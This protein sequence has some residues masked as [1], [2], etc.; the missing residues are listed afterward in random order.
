VIVHQGHRIQRVYPKHKTRIEVVW[1]GLALAW[2]AGFVDAIGYLTLREIYVANMSGN[3]VSV[4]IHLSKRDWSA[5]WAHACPLLAFVPGLVAGGVIVELCKRSKLRAP[6]VLALLLE[7]MAL[8]LFI[9]I[10]RQLISSH[11][12]I[13]ET[14]T[15]A[16]ALLVG[17][18]A[19]SMGLQNGALQ[20]IGALKDVH[21]YVT[22][23][24]LAMAD[25]FTQYLFWIGRR[26]RQMSGTR[27]CRIL[28]YSTRQHS[29]RTAFWAAMLWTLYIIGAVLGALARLRCG[30]NI[31]L[32]PIGLLLLVAFVDA[33]KPARREGLSS[34]P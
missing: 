13:Q 23:T 6:L 33:I 19:F 4:A 27:I 3:T 11:G 29:L 32:I 22:G 21:T 12:T 20:R 7:A 14:S 5:A 8:A 2:T 10:G 24:L 9:I 26:L 28:N 18:L 30:I 15:V 17:L 31:F 1:L 34:V 16:Y 25:G